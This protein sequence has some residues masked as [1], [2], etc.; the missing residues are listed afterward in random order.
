VGKSQLQELEAANQGVP[1]RWEQRG[2]NTQVFLS[3]SLLSLFSHSPG[4]GDTHFLADLPTSIKSIKI[5]CRPHLPDM[6]MG[7]PDLGSSHWELF[8]GR[9]EARGV[10]PPR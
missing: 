5:T 7:Q 3:L 2:K 9:V 4:N 1:N 8:P 6:S 10:P